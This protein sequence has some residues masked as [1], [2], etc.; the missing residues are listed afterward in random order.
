[1]KEDIEKELAQIKDATVFLSI[2]LDEINKTSNIRDN[3]FD[4]I[5]TILYKK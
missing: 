1:M 3:C 4:K 2:L 5:Q